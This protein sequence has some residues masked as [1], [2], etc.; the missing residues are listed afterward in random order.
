VEQLS[1]ST[2]LQI[3]VAEDNPAD[4][5]L[6][7]QALNEHGLRYELHV[8][9]DGA[10]ALHLLCRIKNGEAPCPDLILLDLNLPKRNGKEIL[11]YIKALPQYSCT[12]VVIV[13][14]S[15]SLVDRYDTA[16]LGARSYF[17]KPSSLA[18]FM[19]LGHVVKT[20]CFGTPG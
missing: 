17:R 13:T 18:E 8:V 7:R 5:F 1:S 16:R 2:P 9:T 11:Q 20:V 6:I 10:E 19:Q 12:P 14:S 3:L 4:V 15:D